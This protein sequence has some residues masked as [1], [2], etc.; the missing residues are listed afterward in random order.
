M[1]PTL[2]DCR[3]EWSKGRTATDRPSSAQQ[4]YRTRGMQS[5]LFRFAGSK[6]DISR[7]FQST[8][9]VQKAHLSADW[10]LGYACADACTAAVLG[11]Q[12]IR[13]RAT[14]AAKKAVH[15]SLSR[16]RSGDRN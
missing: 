13:A 14:F 1:S 3:S 9:S 16:R 6:A 2:A 10:L 12:S 15:P 11:Q 4:R 8:I 7:A 5:G